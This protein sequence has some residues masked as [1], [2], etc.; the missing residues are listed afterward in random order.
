MLFVTYISESVGQVQLFS[1]GVTSTL[2]STESR[3]HRDAANSSRLYLCS[4]A[5]QLRFWSTNFGK[6]N[7]GAQGS[8]TGCLKGHFLLHLACCWLCCCD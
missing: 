3:P 2:M 7:E 8:Q 6:G 5:V 1:G 4:C